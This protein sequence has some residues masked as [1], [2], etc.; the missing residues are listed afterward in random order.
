[1]GS[2]GAYLFIFFICTGLRKYFFNTDELM[3]AHVHVNV[4]WT[5]VCLALRSMLLC[6][7]SQISRKLG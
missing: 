1:M 4:N 6:E 2:A 5:S 7:I 3:P